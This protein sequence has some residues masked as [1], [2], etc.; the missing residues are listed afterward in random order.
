MERIPCALPSIQF[1]KCSV[2]IAVISASWFLCY[3]FIELLEHFGEGVG[4]FR[5]QVFVSTQMHFNKLG[6]VVFG[7]WRLNAGFLM[8]EQISDADTQPIREFCKCA[9]IRQL[10][11]SSAL[12]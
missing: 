12:E 9:R 6:H 1:K 4:R 2:A 8:L 7:F 3:V 10:W 5:R 11:T